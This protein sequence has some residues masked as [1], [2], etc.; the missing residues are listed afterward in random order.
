[1]AGV[2]LPF[3]TLIAAR[4]LLI[5]VGRLRVCN[6]VD[7]DSGAGEIQTRARNF[8]TPRGSLRFSRAR[9]YFAEIANIQRLL[10]GLFCRCCFC[11]L[12]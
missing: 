1:M 9:V 2:N 11:L 5:S 4:V 3:R 10:V 7:G 8:E 12:V 6:F